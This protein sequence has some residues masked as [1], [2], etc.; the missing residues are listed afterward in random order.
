MKHAFIQV[1]F[2]ITNLSVWCVCDFSIHIKDHHIKRLLCKKQVLLDDVSQVKMSNPALSIQQIQT[3]LS[4]NLSAITQDYESMIQIKRIC[5]NMAGTFTSKSLHS[6]LREIAILQ[7]CRHTNLA[8]YFGWAE[9]DL[10]SYSIF[11]KPY[12]KSLSQR[13]AESTYGENKKILSLRYTVHMLRGLQYLHDRYIVHGDLKPANLLLDE[14]DV[15][16]L[17]DFGLSASKN[18]AGIRGTMRY[19]APELL[20]SG[21]AYAG[22]SL[23]SDI[24]AVGVIIW[25]LLEIQLPWGHSSDREVKE[26]VMEGRLLPIKDSWP[27]RYK[28]QLPVMWQQKPAD[29]PKVGALLSIFEPVFKPFEDDVPALGAEKPNVSNDA[30]TEGGASKDASSFGLSSMFE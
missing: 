28:E 23:A 12:A 16:V 11:M 26:H 4:C 3:L 22:N 14:H 13:L 20:R 24:F 18:A 7:H 29:R 10:P 27:G 9:S 30:S 17:A 5:H 21:S 1:G 19:L 25:Q 6:R 8:R 2:Y 15:L